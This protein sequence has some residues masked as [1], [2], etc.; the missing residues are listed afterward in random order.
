M[1][2]QRYQAVIAVIADG[3]SVRVAAEKAGVSRQTLHA[4]T[5]T[6]PAYSLVRFRIPFAALAAA[7]WRSLPRMCELHSNPA[8][9]P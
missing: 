3:L 7:T 4:R 5:L 9:M 1:V 6:S 2:E 8:P